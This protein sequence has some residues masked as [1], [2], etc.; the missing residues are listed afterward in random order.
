MLPGVEGP[1]LARDGDEAIEDVDVV[2][3]GGLVLPYCYR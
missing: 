3:E 1:I 2:G